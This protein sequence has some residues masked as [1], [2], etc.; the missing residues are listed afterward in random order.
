MKYFSF[1]V[2]ICLTFGCTND[3]KHVDYIGYNGKVY[4]VDNDFSIQEAFAVMDGK[5]EAVGSSDEVLAQY[6]SNQE[7][8]LQGKNVYPGFFDAHGHLMSYAEVKLYAPLFGTKSFD[9]VLERLQDFQETNDFSWLIGRGWDQNDWE[10]KE[11]P[12]KDMLDV[13]FPDI[14]VYLFRIDGHAALLNQKALD[15]VGFNLD[16]TIDR[17]EIIKIRW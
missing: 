3:K 8:D 5:I 1:I 6:S 11:F 13:M 4:T 17:G 15:M 7:V 2:I 16:T 9:E 10:V 14:P 12:S